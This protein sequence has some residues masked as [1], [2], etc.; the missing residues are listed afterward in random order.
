MKIVELLK[1]D[2]ELQKLKKAYKDKYNKNAPPYN[3]DE[4][5]GI[6]DYKNRLRLKL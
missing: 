3:Y 6:E 5:E 4:Y 2:E 1:K